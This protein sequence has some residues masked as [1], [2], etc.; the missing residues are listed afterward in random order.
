MTP[1]RANI[2]GPPDVATRISASMAALPLR[3][4]GLGLRKFR[5]VLAGVLKGDELATARQRYR[6]FEMSLPP[7]I[8][9][10]RA[11]AVPNPNLA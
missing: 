3:G 11:V 8:S 2:V 9:H 7:A 5:D 6:L 4:L 10:S 1:I